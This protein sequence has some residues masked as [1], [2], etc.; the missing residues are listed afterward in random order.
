[1]LRIKNIN[2]TGI[3]HVANEVER[4][5]D[6]VILPFMCNKILFCGIKSTFYIIL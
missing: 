4:W 3:T 2:K 5:L 6:I 1:M